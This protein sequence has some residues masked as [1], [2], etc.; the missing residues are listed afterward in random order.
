MRVNDAVFGV[1]LL[2][3]AAAMIGYTTTF[4]EMPGQD[5]GPALFPRLIGAG[6]AA[7]GLVLIVQG[8]RARREV[9]WAT[10]GDWARS[11]RHRLNAFLV[12]ACLLFYILAADLLGFIPCAFLILALLAWRFGA[13]PLVAL[14]VAVIATL[15]IHVGFYELL[16]VPLPWGLLQPLA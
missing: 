9:A 12:V 13:R 14:G 8:L 7:C 2:L 6:M 1:V 11:P 16:R 5:Y 15:A 4:P 10:L 3:F